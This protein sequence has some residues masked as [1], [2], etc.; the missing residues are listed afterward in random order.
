MIFA[1]EELKSLEI[2]L[3]YDMILTHRCQHFRTISGDLDLS[4]GDNLVKFYSFVYGVV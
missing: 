1:F 2:C 3:I 4:S